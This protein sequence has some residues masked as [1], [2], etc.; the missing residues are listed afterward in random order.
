M[1]TAVII[2][3]FQPYHFG[4]VK[5]VD[6]ALEKHDH[7]VILIGS[8]GL[9]RTRKNPWTWNERADM[10]IAAHPLDE[11]RMSVLPIFDVPGDDEAWAERVVGVVNGA[12]PVKSE[13]TLVGHRKDDTSF[14]L[15]LFPDWK[16]DEVESHGT[17]DG[18]S[19]RKDYFETSGAF[20]SKVEKDVPPST[21]ARMQQFIDSRTL[22]GLKAQS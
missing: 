15:D 9:P 21:L 10:I 12:A 22:D 8:A 5:L 7:V 16:L 2:G 13:I 17:R 6:H 3:R 18:T 19:I 11:Y 1:K 4:H 14:Y 20:E